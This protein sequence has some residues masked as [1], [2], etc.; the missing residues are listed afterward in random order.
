MENCVFMIF[1]S[2]VK[3]VLHILVEMQKD[4]QVRGD[5][6]CCSDTCFTYI[7]NYFK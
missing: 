3:N 6:V 4:V 7:L 2:K 5:L 1:F